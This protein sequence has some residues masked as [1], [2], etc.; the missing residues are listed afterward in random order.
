MAVAVMILT[1]LITVTKADDEV[2]NTHVSSAPA[3]LQQ[4]QSAESSNQDGGNDDDG[5]DNL[6]KRELQEAL[7]AELS[8][9]LLAGEQKRWNNNQRAWGKRDD[10]SSRSSDDTND[11]A[12]KRW[13]EHN[14]RLWGKRDFDPSLGNDNDDVMHALDKK[15][16]TGISRTWGKRAWDGKTSRMWGKRAWGDSNRA[17]GKRSGDP[18]GDD[19]MYPIADMP[20]ASGLSPL[21]SRSKRS[22]SAAAGGLMGEDLSKRLWYSGYKRKWGKRSALDVM[23]RHPQQLLQAKRGWDDGGQRL[24]GKRATAAV[25]SV[26]RYDVYQQLLDSYLQD[27]NA[28]YQ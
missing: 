25:P 12:A 8:H 5:S 3:S 15:W 27:S 28:R 4:E 14:S 18:Y 10:G 9:Q 13:N 17:W 20:S 11:V 23:P 21:T 1:V 19:S 6:V 2:S 16:D 22:A 7:N 24:W 26:S